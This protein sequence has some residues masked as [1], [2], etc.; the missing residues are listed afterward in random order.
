MVV[1]DCADLGLLWSLKCTLIFRGAF[2]EHPLRQAS[3]A[4]VLLTHPPC[5]MTMT[6][7]ESEDV[8]DVYLLQA[9]CKH[10]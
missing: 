1:C 6:E 8:W 2:V 9:L 5:E 10:F 7:Q 4:C 3:A